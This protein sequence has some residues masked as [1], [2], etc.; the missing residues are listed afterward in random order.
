MSL[1]ENGKVYHV[2]FVCKSRSSSDLTLQ[3]I[4]LDTGTNQVNQIASTGKKNDD[5]F[6]FE[7]LKKDHTILTLRTQFR[8]VEKKLEDGSEQTEQAIQDILDELAQHENEQKE[9]EAYTKKINSKLASVNRTIYALQRIKA[10][11]QK[12]D[13]QSDPCLSP[14]QCNIHPFVIPLSSRHYTG[15]ASCALKIRIHTSMSLDWDKW[16]LHI[17]ISN[18]KPPLQ[19]KIN[20]ELNSTE[21]S[22]D[23]LTLLMP[24]TGLSDNHIWERDIPVD[25]ERLSFPVHV[26]FHLSTCLDV[27]TNSL[28]DHDST[29]CPFLLTTSDTEGKQFMFHLS[30]VT[31]DDLHFITPCTDSVLKS[32]EKDGIYETTRFLENEC[33]RKKL[34]DNTNR[35][36][37]A[38]FEQIYPSHASSLQRTLIDKSELRLEVMI[39]PEKTLD[40]IYGRILSTFLK[41]GQTL[42]EMQK[43]MQNQEQA[44]FTLA[45]YPESPI[46][47]S[48]SK[49]TKSVV[50]SSLD[51]NSSSSTRLLVT[52]TIQCVHPIVLLKMESALLSRLH[53][54]LVEPD[55]QEFESSQERTTDYYKQCKKANKWMNRLEEQFRMD[56]SQ[57]EFWNTLEIAI[58]QLRLLHSQINIG[59]VSI[60]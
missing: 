16:Y 56:G 45:S 38:R 57:D 59:P 60:L 7:L 17:D 55:Q 40:D 50:G 37:L 18:Q 42:E 15:R 28:S 22:M 4:S 39:P 47:V 21:N 52:L 33:Q 31:L 20:R 53:Y 51:R 35:Y 34:L 26:N 27:D 14:F 46:L 43:I 1:K 19:E 10:Q 30:E 29:T 3:M 41:E 5:G 44:V 32:L 9:M 48:L 23:G 54:F 49:E 11:K 58:D 36:P 12:L 25:M 2:Q 24:L 13:D 8:K 6:L